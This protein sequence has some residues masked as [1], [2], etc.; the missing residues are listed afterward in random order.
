MRPRRCNRPGCKGMMLALS[1]F[2]GPNPAHRM[3]FCEACGEEA[4]WL[5]DPKLDG[6]FGE[7]HKFREDEGHSGL[8]MLSDPVFYPHRL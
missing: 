7:L 3:Y 1:W 6:S 5:A 4:P 2:Y 8:S